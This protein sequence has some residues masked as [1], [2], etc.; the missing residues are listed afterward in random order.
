MATIGLK[1]LC[2]A[3]RDPLDEISTAQLEAL[4][5]TAT[6]AVTRGER[7]RE[8]TAAVRETVAAFDKACSRFRPDSDLEGLNAAAGSPVAVGPLLLEAV[9]AAL[10]AAR[11]TDGDVDPTVGSALIALGYDRDFGALPRA[12]PGGRSRLVVFAQIPGWPA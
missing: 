8:A 5:T 1:G 2:P 9:A 10:R 7:L 11:L 3:P 4:G 6:V 12:R